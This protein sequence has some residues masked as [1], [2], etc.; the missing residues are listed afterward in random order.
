MDDS[1]DFD[2]KNSDVETPV[3]SEENQAGNVTGSS[4]IATRTDK[5][6]K[7]SQSTPKCGTQPSASAPKRPNIGDLY[8][9]KG[10]NISA[11]GLK[12]TLAGTSKSTTPSRSTPDSDS[13]SAAT[14]KFWFNS[15]KPDSR[16][17]SSSPGPHKTPKVAGQSNKAPKVAGQSNK[18]LKVAGQ[19]S[20]TPKVAGQGNK[21]P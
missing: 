6:T 14:P 19:S 3:K 4:N 11:A 17:S 15:L 2:G 20:K 5:S 7:R 16:S 10:G 12:K 8:K 1:S 9:M 21:I 18:I 13:Q